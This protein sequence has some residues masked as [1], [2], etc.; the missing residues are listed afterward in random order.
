MENL[1]L[2]HSYGTHALIDGDA[3]RKSLRR[4]M[5]VWVRLYIVDIVVGE[6]GVSL[7]VFSCL[8]VF[9]LIPGGRYG[10]EAQ[11]LVLLDA[12]ASY[13]VLPWS[14]QYMM[15]MEAFGTSMNNMLLGGFGGLDASSQYPHHGGGKWR[16]VAGSKAPWDVLAAGCRSSHDIHWSLP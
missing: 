16:Q 7:G 2:Y 14:E 12:S 9:G 8:L 11:D 3:S 6:V 1:Q 4:G 15:R 10:F 5:G 13:S